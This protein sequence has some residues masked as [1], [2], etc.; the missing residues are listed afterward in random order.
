MESPPAITVAQFTDGYILV[1]VQCEERDR[2]TFA[3]IEA[4]IRHIEASN[5]VGHFASIEWREA[6]KIARA[7]AEVALRN[8]NEHKR[9]HKCLP[10]PES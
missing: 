8:L 4:V 3:Y 9:E 5:A 2:L 7:D 6:T 1:P 10:D